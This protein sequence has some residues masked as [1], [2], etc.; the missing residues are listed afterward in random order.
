MKPAPTLHRLALATMA[1]TY[2]HVLAGDGRLAHF[3]ALAVFLLALTTAGVAWATQQQRRPVIVAAAAALALLG[4]RLGLGG[5]SG[6]LGLPPA[7]VTAGLG[8]GLA[9]LATWIV[10]AVVLAGDGPVHHLPV[11]SAAHWIV[12]LVGTVS[13][14]AVMLLGS[15]VTSVGAT[16]ACLDWPLCHG[17]LVP[18]AGDG[19]VWLSF[20]HRLAAVAGGV[21]VLTGFG[22][23]WKHQQHRPGLMGL[24]LLAVGLYLTQVLVGALAVLGRVPE[25]LS[26]IHMATATALFATMVLLTV[27]SYYSPP[28]PAAAGASV[29]AAAAVPV[30]SSAAHLGAY[31]QLMK[32]RIVILLLIT[33][34]A[35]MWVAYGGL[36]PL[37]VT[38]WTML[39][40]TLSCGGANAVNMWFDRDIDAVMSRT[41]QRPVPSGRLL[42]EQ[43]LAFG[44]GCGIVSTLLLAV[45]VNV[46]AALLSLGGYLFYTCI[47]TMLLK[48]STAQNIVIGGA[49]GAVPPL[50]GWAAIT[51]D[52]SWSAMVM[53]LIV[54]LWT[55]PHF[56]ALALF[57]NEDYRRAGVP[58]LP[59][60]AGE[61]ETKRQSLWYTVVLLPVSLL[62][63][64]LGSVGLLYFAAALALGAG[65]IYYATR[66]Y[67]AR[68]GDQRPSHLLFGYSLLYL[69][70]LFLAMV[71]DARA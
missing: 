57:R 65:F 47:Y 71:V 41:R 27:L 66:Q 1:A 48:R 53:F 21:S 13:V 2:L 11:R 50:V 4:G 69:G 8:V 23:T 22:I 30:L 29:A 32:P 67:Y 51:G 18:S 7:L 46:P 52:L 55:P 42:P 25:S 61:H 54:F 15:Y 33:G 38:F 6:A 24:S 43:A 19:L 37:G 59:V 44:V 36:P 58:M 5:V 3:S 10:F 28:I 64:P 60:V 45:A 56:W 34:Y 35:A 9:F 20:L 40:L 12:P 39:G 70:L 68:N 63:Y 62:L 49:A 26:A 17:A 31:L 16:A 14:F